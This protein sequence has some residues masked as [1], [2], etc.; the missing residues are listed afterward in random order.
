MLRAARERIGKSQQA[1]ADETKKTQ[2]AV[3]GWEND[4]VPDS[5]LW[6]VIAEAYGIPLARIRRHFIRLLVKS[7]AA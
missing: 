4:A 1:I 7:S 6:P 2:G 5:K 3:S